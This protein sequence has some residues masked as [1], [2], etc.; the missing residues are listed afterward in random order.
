MKKFTRTY[1]SPLYHGEIFDMY[2]GDLKPC[3]F[4]IETT[5]LSAQRGNKII[6]TACMT[7]DGKG[8]KITQFLA[9][10]P[11]EE[12]RVLMS[13]MEFLCE[14]GV[15]YLITYNGAAFDI[16]F[17]KQRLELLH[18]PYILNMYEYD[19]YNFIRS[20]TNLKSEIGSISQKNVEAYFGIG[21]NRKDVISGRESVKLFSE[22]AV[23][24]DSVI[25]K[26]ILTHNR[27]DVLQLNHLVNIVGQDNFAGVLGNRDCQDS[28]AD[29]LKD[30]DCQ[31]LDW[32]LAQ[33]GAGLPSADGELTARP[34][35]AAGC[36]TVTGRQLRAP[37]KLSDSAEYAINAN[38]F[39]DTAD[40]ISAEFIND[41]SSYQIKIPLESH[42]KSQF[43][44][45]KN[46][47][48]TAEASGDN[49]QHKYAGLL[50]LS[51]NLINDYLLLV[52]NG[53]EL[54]REINLLSILIS[55]QIYKRV[56]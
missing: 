54:N 3:I 43:I 47:L 33:T 5:G 50:R 26:I 19:L 41:N 25:E 31:N 6:L 11:Y 36:L 10:T 8:S 24:Q 42:E 52:D 49:A 4:D 18:L 7:A 39:P 44:D 37:H 20:N 51:D 55:T 32:A 21:T 23:N 16:P 29:V 28:L 13:T 22:Y 40:S 1:T 12:D 27:E 15:D 2:H 46:I 53:Q 34:R 17:V 30:R 56:R 9:E 14:E 35:L 48:A 38:I 45:I